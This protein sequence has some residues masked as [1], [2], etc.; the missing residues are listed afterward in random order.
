LLRGQPVCRT[1]CLQF[2]V[3]SALSVQ[4][5][6]TVSSEQMFYVVNPNNDLPMTDEYLKWFESIKTWT[7]TF[8]SHPDLAAMKDALASND[9]YM[10]CGH[11]GGV[12]CL[13]SC[14]RIEQVDCKAVVFLMGCGSSKM[15]SHGPIY[16][17]DAI[18][19]SYL[20]AGS[21]CVVGCLWSV[22]APDIDRYTTELLELWLNA[23]T[24]SAQASS[25]SKKNNHSEIRSLLCAVAKAKSACKL[26]LLTGGATVSYGLPIYC[27]EPLSL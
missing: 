3:D 25:T 12:K 21:P 22:T 7:G 18:P 6:K 8:H 2:L 5:P 27:D 10:Y 23:K 9:I 11:S 19:L 15:I 13:C 24:A 1:P 20:V 4:L 17:P 26:P 14:S 16:E